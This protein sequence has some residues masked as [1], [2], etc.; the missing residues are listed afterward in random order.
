[1]HRDQWFSAVHKTRLRM[2]ERLEEGI[3]EAMKNM[4][5]RIRPRPNQEE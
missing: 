3:P 5:V 2:A 4:Y 1:M